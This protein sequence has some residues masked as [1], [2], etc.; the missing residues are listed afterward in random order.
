MRSRMF[1]MLAE[2]QMQN[3]EI[4]RFFPS[5]K[6]LASDSAKAHVTHTWTG[7]FFATRVTRRVLLKRSKCSPTRVTS[8]EEFSPIGHFFEYYESSRKF[9]A[10]FPHSSGFI[11]ILAKNGLGY[12]FGDFFT[13]SSGHPESNTFFWSQLIGSLVW[14][15]KLAV[16][17]ALILNFLKNTAQSKPSSDRWK[18][19]QSGHPVRNSFFRP[20]TVDKTN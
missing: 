14:M 6:S 12:I 8:L 3:R 16:N 20:H 4:S 15:E 10:T 7:H 18:F 1:W 17:F 13:I 2:V 19:D 9:W 5:I 11:L